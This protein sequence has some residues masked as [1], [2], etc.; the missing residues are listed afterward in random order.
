MR[1]PSMGPWGR[2]STR[3]DYMILFKKYSMPI[4]CSKELFLAMLQRSVYPCSMVRSIIPIK[5][6][7][8]ETLI[9]SIKNDRAAL[10]F[11]IAEPWFER[12]GWKNRSNSNNGFMINGIQPILRG[13]VIS[14]GNDSCALEYRFFP[15]SFLFPFMIAW[16]VGVSYVIWTHK[17]LLLPLLFLTL[18]PIVFFFLLTPV[19]SICTNHTVKLLK[20][21]IKTI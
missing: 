7:L 18:S 11:Q 13:K 2:R 1:T 19:Y 20:D 4:P 10:R 16:C 21:L 14:T 6:I 12:L 9:G 15:D 5:G 3:I 8:S 17:D